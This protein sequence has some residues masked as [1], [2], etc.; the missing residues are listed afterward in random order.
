MGKKATARVEM[1]N[2]LS[3]LNH[4]LVVEVAASRPHRAVAKALIDVMARPPSET[5]VTCAF[6]PP[7]P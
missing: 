5:E 3:S 1:L 2:R 4:P 7:L 6:L